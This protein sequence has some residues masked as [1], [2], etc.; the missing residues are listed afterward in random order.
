MVFCEMSRTFSSPL[1]HGWLLHLL[2]VLC[3]FHVDTSGVTHWVRQR[4]WRCGVLV[5]GN[6]A[7]WLL[8]CTYSPKHQI[9][10]QATWDTVLST[11]LSKPL[12]ITK[13]FWRVNRHLDLGNGIWWHPSE[14]YVRRWSWSLDS[15]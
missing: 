13:F 1:S 14:G 10:D 6:R 5:I 11:K 2:A 4:N 12:S 8:R 15:T 3:V 9:A 7:L